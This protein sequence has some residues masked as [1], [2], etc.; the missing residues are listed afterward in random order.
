MKEQVKELIIGCLETYA[1]ILLKN[2]DEEGKVNQLQ[3]KALLVGYCDLIM[4][5]SKED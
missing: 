3:I 2:T 5:E 1:D 4:D